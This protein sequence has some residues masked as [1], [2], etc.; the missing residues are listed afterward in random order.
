MSECVNKYFIFNNEKRSC[1]QFEDNLLKNGKSLY[2][3]IR[4]IDGKPLFLQRHLN[5]LENS[6]KLADVNIWV[7]EYDI[8]AKLR[9][10]VRINDTKIGNVKV[11]FKFGETDSFLAYFVKHLMKGNTKL[12]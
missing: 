5:R 6:A 12:V 11:I 4:I 7:S 10:L 3:V 8:K 9:E 2:E 1:E